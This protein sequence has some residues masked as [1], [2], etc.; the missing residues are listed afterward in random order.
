MYINYL[1]CNNKT[2]A[3]RPNII[4]N[5]LD[6]APKTH[7]AWYDKVIKSLKEDIIKAMDQIILDWNDT[8]CDYIN[9]NQNRIPVRQILDLK[10]W[11]S[12]AFEVKREKIKSEWWFIKSVWHPA[13][14]WDFHNFT[15]NCYRFQEHWALKPGEKSLIIVVEKDKKDDKILKLHAEQ[16]EYPWPNAF[17]MR[18]MYF[19]NPDVSEER[20]NEIILNKE[21]IGEKNINEWDKESSEKSTW[22]LKWFFDKLK[23]K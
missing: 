2:M 18:W 13:F 22:K 7:K 14:L 5:E 19:H 17:V 8:L 1:F 23:K 6:Q 11:E 12:L 4:S 15:E 3:N 10:A 9:D 21:E 20:F 16:L